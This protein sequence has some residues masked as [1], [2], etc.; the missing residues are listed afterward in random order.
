M[1][2]SS[3][4]MESEPR[5]TSTR[6][7][8]KKSELPLDMPSLAMSYARQNN[9]LRKTLRRFEK[10]KQKQMKSIDGDIWELQKFMQDLKCVTA[11]SADDIL[12]RQKT[13]SKDRLAADG[14]GR[15]KTALSTKNLQNVKRTA[16]S[17]E[18][19]FFKVSSG[20]TGENK[21]D[22]FKNFPSF[23]DL[24]HQQ[25]ER[26]GSLS[27]RLTQRRRSYSVGE[28]RSDALEH[29]R[30]VSGYKQTLFSRRRSLDVGKIAAMKISGLDYK[31]GDQLTYESPVDPSPGKNDS[32]C[33]VGTNFHEHLKIPKTQAENIS[34][35][36]NF[37][38]GKLNDAQRFRKQTVFSFQR[39]PPIVIG[40]AAV[41]DVSQES[42]NLTVQDKNSLKPNS[43]SPRVTDSGKLLMR[44]GTQDKLFIK[45]PSPIRQLK[46][47]NNTDELMVLA[48]SSSSCEIDSKRK[49]NRQTTFYKVNTSSL[50]R[51]ENS[52]DSTIGFLPKE[53]NKTIRKI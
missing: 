28:M 13:P 11:I 32:G 12:N 1:F 51:K 8:I 39:A 31:G 33:A 40:E 42:E 22:N 7:Q 53:K 30:T 48:T 23:T 29:L 17:T 26:K 10:E 5:R 14:T 20:S 49:L 46:D 34:D 3:D 38:N 44:R 2:S 27:G 35:D 24:S 52:R 6:N 36:I 4:D 50:L 47:S 45:R 18:N 25:R 16:R 19:I 9:D 41:D 37:E 43:Q 21:I 15:D